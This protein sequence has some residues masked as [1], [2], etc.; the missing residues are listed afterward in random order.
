[1]TRTTD[2]LNV[3]PRAYSLPEAAQLARLSVRSL[4][5]QIENGKLI[6]TRIGERVL[7]RPENLDAFLRSHDVGA[8]S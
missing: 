8:Q 1:M 4:Q 7:V 6:A 5:R 2:L 3:P